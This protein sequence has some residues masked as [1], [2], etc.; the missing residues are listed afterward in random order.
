M[1]RG[2]TL[3]ELLVT[4][5]IIAILAGLSLVAVESARESAR[6]AR[7]RATIAKLHELVIE[8]Y[9]AYRTRRVALTLP[10]NTQPIDAVRLRLYAVRDLMRMEMPERRAD[11]LGGPATTIPEPRLHVAYRR[12]L[13][14]AENKPAF[15]TH[16]H[17]E[18]EVFYRMVALADPAALERFASRDIGDTDRDG[19]PEFLDGWGRPIYFL[20]W[21]PAFRDSD[22]QAPDPQARHDPFDSTRIDSAAFQLFPLIYSPGPDGVYGVDIAPG[23]DYS[24]PPAVDPYH[25]AAGAP[26][27]DGGELDNIH[28]HR[29]SP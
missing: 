17:V 18:A 19:E 14:A 26:I 28:N 20:R 29:L 9:E 10:P 8:R 15:Q 7:T 1:R 6:E 24:S 22:I 16:T 11:I 3:A 13:T 12:W 21:A 5:T 25:S 23:T 4:V 2:F 27:E